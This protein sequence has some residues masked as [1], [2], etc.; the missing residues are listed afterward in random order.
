MGSRRK[1]V[2]AAV[3]VLFALLFIAAAALLVLGFMDFHR[4]ESALSDSKK[5]L[6][7]LY[8]RNPF[9]AE[10]NLQTERANLK[11]LNSEMAGLIAAMSRGQAETVEQSPA[12]FVSQF[13]ESRKALLA[14]AT[15]AGTKVAEGFDFGFGRQMEGKPPVQKDVA[16]LAQ[17]LK[18][19][20]NLC[21][22]LYAAHVG[23][24]Q[25]VGREEFEEDAVAGGAVAASAPT[26]GRGRGRGATAASQVSLNT[27]NAETGVVPEGQQFGKWHFVLVF[28]AKESVLLDVLNGM[29]RDP[30]FAAVTRLELTGDNNVV[31]QG[32]DIAAKEAQAEGGAAK[33]PKTVAPAAARD[34][35]IVSGRDVPVSVRM[36]VDVYQFAKSPAAAAPVEGAK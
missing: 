27:V 15:E 33:T 1:V 19:V 23:E 17:Q 29:A 31:V 21:G 18:I 10:H 25:G 16:R 3:A 2:I 32:G 26:L 6:E 12:K 7:F 11:I 36:D 30:L 28:S 8:G 13:W 34:L 20:E 22:V 35:R 24:L 14:R 5:Q 4:A 9:P